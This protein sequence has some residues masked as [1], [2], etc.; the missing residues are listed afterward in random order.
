MGRK[1]ALLIGTVKYDDPALR[2]LEKVAADVEDFAS[3]LRD[4]AIGAFDRVDQI[5][6][7]PFAAVYSRI[8][9]FFVNADREDLLVLYFSG[10]GLLDDFDE[11]YLA[12]RDTSSNL[13]SG[14]GIPRS[15]ITAQMD[16]SRSRQQVLI[17][18]CCYSGNLAA[19]RKGSIPAAGAFRGR[20]NGRVILAASRDNELAKQSDA[21][22]PDSRNSV[23]THFVVHGL[24]T[25]AADIDG[26]G[27]VTVNEFRTVTS[28]AKRPGI[29]SNKHPSAGPKKIRERLYLRRTRILRRSCRPN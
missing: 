9:E 25:G 15:H 18:D 10:H 3:V 6:D 28:A 24:R 5:V 4:P 23:Y 7:S 27:F 21:S 13:L 2:R 19:G 11:P 14:T 22:I 29:P 16:R 1:L 8:A 20:G 26:N 17:L 12:V